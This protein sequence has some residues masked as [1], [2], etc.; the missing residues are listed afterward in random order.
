M[1]TRVADRRGLGK[2]LKRVLP[3]G[4]F[5]QLTRLFNAV[6]GAIPD[7]WKY[8]AGG[9][10]RRG[11]PPYSLLRDDDVVIQVGAPRDLLAAGRSR[12][13]HFARLVPRGRVLVVEPDPAN[14]EALGRVAERTGLAPRL[15][16]ESRGAWRKAG[17]LV[18]LSHPAHPAANVLEDVLGLD[19]AELLRRGF[20]RI[21][22]SVATLDEI[23]QRAGLAPPRLVSITTN[24]AE[25]A[26]LEGMPRLLAGG[27]PYVS[28][29]STGPGYHERMSELGYE[30]IVRD[31]R[32]YLFRRRGCGD[33]SPG[34]T[35]A[36]DHS[37]R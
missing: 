25:L 18:F 11:K 24:G 23:W 5:R 35:T 36:V 32:G 10:L 15:V 31:D 34:A 20:E 22:V 4:L 33:S 17:E 37:R 27:C 2:Q 19:E 13:I 26:I 16:I 21:R 1:A 12:A 29:A 28:L 3:A 8:A 9:A 14:L 30:Y 7:A 6:T